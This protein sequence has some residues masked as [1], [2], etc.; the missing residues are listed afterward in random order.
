MIAAVA[1]EALLELVWVP[2]GVVA[3]SSPRR[4]ASSA[5]HAP[6]S[7]A[8]WAGRQG[9]RATARWRSRA[10]SAVAAGVV[11]G[12]AVIVSGTHTDAAHAATSSG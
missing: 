2:P 12:V 7:C 9:G 4:C 10:R 6:A 8:G 5:P 11:A 1:L 3:T